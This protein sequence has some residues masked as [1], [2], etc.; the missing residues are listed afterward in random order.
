[1]NVPKFHEV[2]VLGKFV[3]YEPMTLTSPI[4]G[5]RDRNVT[6]AWL[7]WYTNCNVVPPPPIDC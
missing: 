1:M 7:Y 3:G 5:L 4:Y 2:N 6:H